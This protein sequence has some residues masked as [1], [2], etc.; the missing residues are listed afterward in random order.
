MQLTNTYRHVIHLLL[1]VPPLLNAGPQRWDALGALLERWKGER[2]SVSV[3]SSEGR[4]QL[5]APR[6]PA[7]FKLKPCRVL[8]LPW[9]SG[10]DGVPLLV[11]LMK[12]NY[13]WT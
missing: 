1:P 11:I 4:T 8:A 9:G 10:I 13:I 2:K 6:L 5:G 3:L 12:N 7:G